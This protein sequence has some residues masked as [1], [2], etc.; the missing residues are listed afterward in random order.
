MSPERGAIPSNLHPVKPVV[1]GASRPA[2]A[3]SAGELRIGQGR[4][5]NYALPQG[6]R[7]GEDGQFALTLMAP[8]GHALT[9]LVGNAGMPPNYPPDRYAYEKMMALQ[10]QNLRMSKAKQ[11]MPLKGFAQGYQFDV[12]Y[13]AGGGAAH[14][15][16]KV[17]VAP[18]YDTST[19][20]MTAALSDASQW[21]SYASWLP[22]VADQISAIDGG[23]FGARGIMAQNLQ[24]STAYAAAAKEYREFSQRTQQGVTDA[25]NASQDKNNVAFREGLG[26]VQTYVNPYE[27]KVPVELPD[28]YKYFWVNPQGTY[29]GTDDPS[30]NPNNGSTGEWKR[31]PKRQP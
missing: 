6:W 24:N 17:Y 26:G 27:P 19:M 31:L 7:V 11:M 15:V 4:F 10:I 3:K 21:S 28:T 5:F 8:D 2:P 12:D 14:G 29:Q 23:A 1:A 16:V 30:V 25:R 18:A 13:T 9:V 22:L 20:A